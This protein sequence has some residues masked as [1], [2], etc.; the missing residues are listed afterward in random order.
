MNWA[1]DGAVRTNVP[2]GGSQAGGSG[3]VP[4]IPCE[5]NSAGGL[6]PAEHLEPE[7]N[8]PE[9]HIRHQAGHPRPFLPAET[10][11]HYLVSAKHRMTTG[12]IGPG[13][14]DPSAH[15]TAH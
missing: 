2:T 10:S 6:V 7:V 14:H 11:R 9:Y 1:V 5:W 15:F 8:Y 13:C 4:S 12:F 3:H